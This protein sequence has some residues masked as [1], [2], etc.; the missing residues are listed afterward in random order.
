MVKSGQIME[1][2]GFDASLKA[3]ILQVRK[4]DWLQ[5]TYVTKLTFC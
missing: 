2:K 5:M 3:N 1:H 4:A